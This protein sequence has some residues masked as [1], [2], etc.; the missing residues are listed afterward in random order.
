M[1]IILQIFKE[2]YSHYLVYI[3]LINAE[4]LIETSRSEPFKN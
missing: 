2:S 4:R 1:Y 3:F